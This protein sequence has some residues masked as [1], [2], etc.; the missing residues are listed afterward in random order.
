MDISMNIAGVWSKVDKDVEKS[1]KLIKDAGFDAVDF[2]LCGMVNDDHEFNGDDYV[3]IAK[4]YRAIIE[5]NGLYVNQTHTPFTFKSCDYDNEEYY[6]NVILKR[7]VRSLEISAILGAETAI[8]HPLHYSEYHGFEED[9]FNKNMSYYRYLLPYCKEFGVK[10]CVENMFRRDPRRKYIAHDTCSRKEEFIRYV[11]TLD[12]EY[13]VA[14]LDVGHVGLPVQDDEAWDM[15][16][17]LGH[18][19]LQALH[20]HDNDY[21]NDRHLAPYSGIIDWQKVA[22]ALGEIDYSGVFTYEITARTLD[23]VDMEFLPVTLKYYADIAKHI[24]DMIDRS[25][26]QK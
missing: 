4:R 1:A 3:E 13:V 7:M 14:C 21:Q 8:V 10:M 12:S 19:R 25:R 5:S 24:C 17:A 20:I 9:W 2:D 22:K 16:Y 18:D 26:P 6:N 15:A 11:D 23:T